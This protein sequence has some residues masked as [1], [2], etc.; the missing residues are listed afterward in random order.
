MTLR[1][2]LGTHSRLWMVTAVADGKTCHVDGTLSNH[3]VHGGSAGSGAML[4]RG[5]C[6]LLVWPL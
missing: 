3:T 2:N 1:P 6:L 4:L 5:H